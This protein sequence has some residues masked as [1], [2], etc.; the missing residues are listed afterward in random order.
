MNYYLHDDRYIRVSNQCPPGFKGVLYLGLAGPIDKIAEACF[1]AG[2][3]KKMAKV[4]RDA[5]PAEWLLA[6]GETPPAPKPAPVLRTVEVPLLDDEGENLLAY[7]PVTVEET[8]AG[9]SDN[10][11]AWGMLIVIVVGILWILK[12]A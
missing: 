10:T 12:S 1:E 5:V 9:E 11:F 6:F 8:P 3:L 2:Q 7:I 4:S